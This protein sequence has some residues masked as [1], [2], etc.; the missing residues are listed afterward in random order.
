MGENVYE[1]K[2]DF[3]HPE[4]AIRFFATLP[5]ESLPLFLSRPEIVRQIHTLLSENQDLVVRITKELADARC[6]CH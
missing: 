1:V 5:P 2:L 3:K 6:K 4:E